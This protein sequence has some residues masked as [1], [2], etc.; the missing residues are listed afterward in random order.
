MYLLDKY[1]QWLRD[2]QRMSRT[3]VLGETEVLQQTEC[4]LTWQS[5]VSVGSGHLCGRMFDTEYRGV[6]TV[7]EHF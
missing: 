7:G 3:L 5:V 6:C 4:E 1:P 2:E